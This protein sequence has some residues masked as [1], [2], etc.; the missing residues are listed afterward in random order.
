MGLTIHDSKD[1]SGCCLRKA[2]LSLVVR[3]GSLA[4]KTLCCGSI[5]MI[6]RPDT[7]ASHVFE[8]STAINR[9]ELRWSACLL[10]TLTK[11]LALT[12][13]TR[14]PVPTNPSQIL[15]NQKGRGNP[16]PKLRSSSNGAGRLQLPGVRPGLNESHSF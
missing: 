16:S 8:S 10:A 12:S 14:Q 9:Q 5:R 13:L 2:K 6:I 3:R 4:V 7:T 15:V 11:G 1:S